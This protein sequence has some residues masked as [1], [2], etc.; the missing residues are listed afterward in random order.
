MV[1]RFAPNWWHTSF[2][3]SSAVIV[4]LVASILTLVIAFF[5]C[6]GAAKKNRCMLGTVRLAINPTS[7][8]IFKTALISVLHLYPDHV[9]GHGGRG[10]PRL[11]GG[12][13]LAGGALFQVVGKVW[14]PVAAEHRQGPGSG[15]EHASTGRE[16]RPYILKRSHWPSF[17]PL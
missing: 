14:R 10:R 4:I 8:V 5:G 7:K 3:S 17:M 12:P 15:L 1:I 9:C 2:F 13:V 16:F 11:E 6:C